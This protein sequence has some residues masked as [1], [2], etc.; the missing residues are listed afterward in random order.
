MGSN[1]TVT[2]EEVASPTG[3]GIALQATAVG[4]T[5]M[6]CYTQDA[7]REYTLPSTFNT[8]AVS[9]RMYL[10]LDSDVTTYNWPGLEARFYKNH[11]WVGLSVYYRAEATGTYMMNSKGDAWTA[12]PQNGVQ[13]LPFSP[14]Y[15]TS[16]YPLSEPIEFDA[17]RIYMMNYA[18][19]GNNSV[20]ID[21]ISLVPASG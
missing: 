9:L 12:I 8:A 3:N 10:G 15:D 13:T 7:W 19:I 17:I 4:T 2:L 14:L 11:T 5:I 6:S 1:P 18:C 21:D 20:V 16:G